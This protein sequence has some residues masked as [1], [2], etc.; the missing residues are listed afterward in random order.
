MKT[1]HFKAYSFLVEGAL[2]WRMVSTTSVEKPESMSW[3]PSEAS[4]QF[5]QFWLGVKSR[6]PHLGPKVPPD[7]ELRRSPVEKGYYI[8][9]PYS[10]WPP[11]GNDSSRTRSRRT[12]SRTPGSRAIEE[13]AY[14]R[15]LGHI[16][17]IASSPRGAGCVRENQSGQ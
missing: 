16:Y 1:L 15:S 9:E 4:P 10:A 11:W 5:P 13:N 8:W 12:L 14:R 3:A 7:G 6:A 2:E 17:T